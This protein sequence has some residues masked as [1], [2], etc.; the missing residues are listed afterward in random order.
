MLVSIIRDKKC[1]YKNT[2]D[3][4]KL[5]KSFLNKKGKQKQIIYKESI[6]NSIEEDE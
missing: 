1:R 6:K 2:R 4:E 3:K 5:K